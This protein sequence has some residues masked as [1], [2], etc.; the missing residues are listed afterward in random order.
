LV[1]SNR[2]GGPKSFLENFVSGIERRGFKAS[3]WH[4]SGSRAALI[5]TNSW[6]NWFFPLAQRHDVRTVLRV[7]GFY[8][9]EWYDNRTEGADTTDWD[10]KPELMAVNY[11]LQQDLAFSDH[12]IYQSK[13][14]KAMADR[15]LYHRREN[16]S[17][18]LNGVNLETFRPLRERKGIG[19]FLKL[20]VVGLIRA[21]YVVIAAIACLKYVLRSINA[22]LT[23]VGPMR[24]DA[25]RSLKTELT[26]NPQLKE[27]V[28]V[29]GPVRPGDMPYQLAEMDLLVL[30]KP[31]ESC[32]HV[33]C[34]ALACGVPVICAK[35]GGTPEVTGDAGFWVDWSLDKRDWEELGARLANGVLI[36][37]SNISEYS[38]RARQRAEKVLSVERMSD[39]YLEAMGLASGG[40]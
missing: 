37:S 7:N 30:P 22:Q 24:R 32:P 12:V 5:L 26:K 1:G 4:L 18:I 28:H 21:D 3:A 33:V 15:F 27:M 35:T 2:T 13:F 14:C 20:G 36:A 25:E 8:Y 31:F 29:A 23:F 38:E 6:G 9:P 17:V 40:Y 34:E 16:Y 10:L 11:R 39:N 19:K